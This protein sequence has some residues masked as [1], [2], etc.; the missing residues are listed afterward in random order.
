MEKNKPFTFIVVKGW[1][2]GM[3]D[4]GG[5]G[6]VLKAYCEEFKKD[7]NVSLLLKLNPSYLNPQL[8][9]QKLDELN[10]PKDR[11]E[12]KVNIDN[13][14]HKDIPKLY[15]EGDVYV[16][17]QRADAFNLPGLEAMGCG[18]PTI[19]TAFGGQVDYMNEGNGWIINYDLEE[20][21]GDI[22]YEGVKWAIPNIKAL[23]E[24]MRYVY[25]NKEKTKEKGKQAL[26]DV[27]NFT[28]NNSAKKALDF[29]KEI[30][31]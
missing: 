5:V 15:C 27:Q 10:L 1:R 26:K 2:G 31:Y 12:I 3:E 29:L 22:Q 18:L 20:V 19:Q 25:N 8:L 28:W 9:K 7:E 16:C 14:P 24:A 11:P 21:K 6:Y 17:A 4:R 13:M 30:I 23:K